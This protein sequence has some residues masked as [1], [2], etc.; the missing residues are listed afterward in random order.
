[1]ATESPTSSTGMPASSRIRAVGKS[2]AVSIANRFP[3]AFHARRSWIVTVIARASF[4]QCTA[5]YRA[6]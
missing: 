2:Y 3:S 5:G 4:R 1:M 6:V